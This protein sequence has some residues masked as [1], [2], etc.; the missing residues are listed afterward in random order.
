MKKILLTCLMLIASVP[1]WAYDFVVDGIYYDIHDYNQNPEFFKNRWDNFTKLIKEKGGKLPLSD[2]FFRRRNCTSRDGT[3]PFFDQP[4][5]N[6]PIFISEYG[7][8]HWTK[9]TSSWGYGGQPESEEAFHARFK[10]LTDALLDNQ[11]LFGLCY[12]QLT[13]VEQEQNG[14]Y[15]A[16]RVPKFDTAFFRQALSRKAAIEE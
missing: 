16:Q 1:L 2:D 11:R 15:T 12:T 14:L 13:D 9:D 4:Y 6:Q 3:G 8:I 5:D 7:G 10:G